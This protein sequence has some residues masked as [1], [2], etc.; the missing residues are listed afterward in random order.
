MP[1]PNPLHPDHL[2][3]AE[4]LAEAC[5]L[6]ALGLLRLRERCG[7]VSAGTS[8][9]SLHFTADLRGHAHPTGETRA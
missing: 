4:R 8:E 2:R 1:I 5:A 6:L 7:P 9:N 3:P